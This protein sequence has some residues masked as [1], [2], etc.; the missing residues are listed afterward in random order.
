MSYFF[1]VVAVDDQE[2]IE[3]DETDE[4]AK[5]FDGTQ[6]PKLLL[7]TCRKPTKYLLHFVQE[8]QLIIPNVFYYRVRSI[9]INFT[10][11]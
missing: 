4:F 2:I 6:T 11:S 7:T 5:Y 1:C 3:A 9:N 8:L 10:V